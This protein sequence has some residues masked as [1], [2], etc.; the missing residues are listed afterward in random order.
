MSHKHSSPME[1]RR[2]NVRAGSSESERAADT[3]TGVG[4]GSKRQTGGV[5]RPRTASRPIAI[6]PP[7]ASNASNA[8]NASRSAWGNPGAGL[9]LFKKS[10]RSSTGPSHR[11]HADDIPA[12]DL[13]RNA[14][15]GTDSDFDEFGSP[16][17][18]TLIL[19]DVDPDTI[20]SPRLKSLFANVTDVE[21]FQL[22]PSRA[23]MMR[24]P[25][26]NKPYAAAF[27]QFRTAKEADAAQVAMNR[28]RIIHGNRVIT[29]TKL[30]QTDIENPF[31]RKRT[32][33]DGHELERSPC[34]SCGAEPPMVPLNARSVN[35]CYH[36]GQMLTRFTVIEEPKSTSQRRTAA[37]STD[38]HSS[39]SARRSSR[40]RS[41]TDKLRTV[42]H[43][44]LSDNARERGRFCSL[45][46]SEDV[47]DH[48]KALADCPPEASA[49]LQRIVLAMRLSGPDLLLLA[50]K[51][52][53]KPYLKSIAEQLDWTASEKKQLFASLQYVLAVTMC[54]APV[55][56]C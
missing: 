39:P 7:R 20:S 35:F 43:L 55:F 26:S 23:A 13:E 30:A 12:L 17:Q 25:L 37:P 52:Q 32:E 3:N 24:D 50:M 45:R 21:G 54:T 28:R 22:V 56:R 47:V 44:A 48:I 19:K 5:A 42:G 18:R 34:P 1:T 6:P 31:V 29:G 49:A 14:S 27:V 8:S 15:D 41:R 36:C 38:R 33:A 40:P 11:S 16:N 2:R 46:R 10:P 4:G 9:A 51:S 53:L